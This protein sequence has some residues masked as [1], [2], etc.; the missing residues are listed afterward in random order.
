MCG[1]VPQFIA[2]GA[3][4]NSI[5]VAQW[6]AQKEGF[7]S[8]IGCIGKDDYGQKLK[9]AASAAGVKTLYM[10]DNET[11]TGKCAVLVTADGER[12]LI[13]DLQVRPCD[14]NQSNRE[15]CLL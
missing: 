6:M 9:D 13:T 5:R 7:T 12:S 8:Y 15:T 10:E 4:Q 2:G 14:N 3:T 11:E 1:L